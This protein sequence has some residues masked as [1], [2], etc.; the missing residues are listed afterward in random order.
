MTFNRSAR[1]IP[2]RVQDGPGAHRIE[3]VIFQDPLPDG[4][5]ADVPA[6]TVWALEWSAQVV[7]S[8]GLPEPDLI[9]DLRQTCPIEITRD[10]CFETVQFMSGEAVSTPRPLAPLGAPT[11]RTTI[12]ADDP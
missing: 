5:V 9:L 12:G 11:G 2:E 3:D 8:P 6:L 7:P 10:R 1:S 4:F